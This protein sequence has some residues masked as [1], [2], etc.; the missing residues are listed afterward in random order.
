MRNT[1]RTQTTITRNNVR[2][3]IE[4]WETRPNYIL[5]CSG[6]S[7]TPYWYGTGYR[8]KTKKK[9]ENDIWNDRVSNEYLG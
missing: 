9:T 5:V 8:I 1:I 4:T 7:F 6:L 2:F 3:R